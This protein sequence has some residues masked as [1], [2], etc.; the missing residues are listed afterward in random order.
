LNRICAA[1]TKVATSFSR[2]GLN[3]FDPPV[4]EELE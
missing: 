2:N 1:I 3:E 4:Q